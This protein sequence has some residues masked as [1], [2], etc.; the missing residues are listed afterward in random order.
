MIITSAGNDNSSNPRYPVAFR[1]EVIGV[2]NARRSGKDPTSNYGDFVDISA[3]GDVSY[4]SRIY[5]P[6]GTSTNTYH[7][8]GTSFSAPRVLGLLARLLE[9]DSQLSPQEG[10]DILIEMRLL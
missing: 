6:T 5:L 3:R 7:T 2:A 4:I 8:L 9:E 1:E 10:M